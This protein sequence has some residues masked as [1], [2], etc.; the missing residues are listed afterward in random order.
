MVSR[1]AILDYGSDWGLRAGSAL[2]SEMRMPGL[3]EAVLMVVGGQGLY[4]AASGG[5]GIV[6]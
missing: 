3:E 1:S 2:E 4:D 6:V 5:D